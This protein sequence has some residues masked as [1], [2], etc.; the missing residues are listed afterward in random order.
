VAALCKRHARVSFDFAKNLSKRLRMT[1]LLKK[2][3]Q[4]FQNDYKSP[5]FENSGYANAKEV[6]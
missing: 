2:R 3:L 5:F 4:N 1:K 6:R